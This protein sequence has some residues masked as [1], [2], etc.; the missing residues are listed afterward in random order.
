MKHLQN[1]HT[2]STYCD[3]ADT[4]EQMIETAIEKGFESIGFS[5]HAYMPFSP[6]ATSPEKMDACRKEVA[7][8]KE[9]YRGR[10]GIFYG[11]EVEMYSPI[12]LDGYDYLIGSC[13]YF[14]FDGK[15]VAYDRN[16]QTVRGVIDEWF[17]GDG[18]AYAKAY[19]QNLTRLPERGDFDIIG[20]FDLITKHSEKEHFFDTECDEY[21]E[22]AVR[23]MEALAG[24][25]PFFEVNTGAIARGYRKT[26]YPSPFLTR[27]LHDFGFKAII[28][29]DCHHREDLDCCFQEAARLL[30]D[31]GFTERYILTDDGFKPVS[32]E[33]DLK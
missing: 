10:I 1:L 28:S 8:L 25:I 15:K 5:G 32:L 13:H 31:S 29:S 16:A 23:A 9:V 11:Q 26:P 24:K 18:L 12:A 14:D 20:H 6:T 33:D 17:G 2:H 4:P 30:L 27:K 3:G 21:K 19:Y 7:R 22:Y